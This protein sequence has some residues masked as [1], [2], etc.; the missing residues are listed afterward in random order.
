ML[1]AGLVACCS[2]FGSAGSYWYTTSLLGGVLG[3]VFLLL[4]GVLALLGLGR[5]LLCLAQGKGRVRVRLALPGS[6]RRPGCFQL[7][8]ISALTVRDCYLCLFSL[9]SA[10]L[11]LGSVPLVVAVLDAS[12]RWCRCRSYR[13]VSPPHTSCRPHPLWSP[14]RCCRCRYSEISAKAGAAMDVTIDMMA[15]VDSTRKAKSFAA[16]KILPCCTFKACPAAKRI[17]RSPPHGGHPGCRSR[18]FAPTRHRS[19][20]H[21][22]PLYLFNSNN[23]QSF[24]ILFVYFLSSRMQKHPSY[25]S[26]Q[27]KVFYAQR[28]AARRAACK[29]PYFSHRVCL[30]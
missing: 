17:P 25:R 22:T 3:G 1:R 30:F 18:F 10:L 15:A 16:Y 26:R 20:H 28:W 24:A 9:N 2:G 14:R 6:V 4:G 23:L 12:R 27:R 13:P 11:F 7:L 5:V 8:R 19:F 29:K 21:F